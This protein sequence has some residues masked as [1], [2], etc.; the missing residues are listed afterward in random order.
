MSPSTGDL[1][2]GGRI[3]TTNTIDVEQFTSGGGGYS[4]GMEAGTSIEIRIYS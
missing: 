1:G 4:D 2:L 3:I